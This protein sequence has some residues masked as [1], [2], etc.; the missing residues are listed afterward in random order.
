MVS[1]KTVGKKASLSSRPVKL[2]SA[3]SSQSVQ[4]PFPIQNPPPPAN[5]Q[6]IQSESI[7]RK[8]IPL[9]PARVSDTRF[10][11]SSSS[12]MVLLVM[13]LAFVAVIAFV[14]ITTNVFGNNSN[15]TSN[16]IPSSPASCAEGQTKPCSL[17]TCTGYSSCHNGLWGACRWQ[18]VCSPYTKTPCLNNSCVYG[19]KEC[20][21]CGS[22]YGPC[23]SSQ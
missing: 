20:D 6:P 17:E 14:F 11:R 15:P 3:R 13:V 9:K 8:D 4:S 7:P 2:T 21:G 19:Y 12:R 16:N 18:L 5:S 22:G 23:I 10:A 1:K